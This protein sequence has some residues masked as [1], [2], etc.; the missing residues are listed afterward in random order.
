MSE[1]KRISN[2]PNHHFFG[3]HDLR[4]TN[5]KEDKVLSLEIEDISHPPLLKDQ[6]LA[7]FIDLSKNN[8]FRS[9]HRT[10][11]YNYPQGARQQWI[12]ETNF[13]TANVRRK[14]NW[15]AFISNADTCIVEE[16]LD[17]P[18]HVLNEK[19][20]DVFYINYSR[21]YRLGVYGY[22][23]IDDKFFKQDLPKKDG[24][25]I[26]NIKTKEK[27]LL[28]SI[29][30]IASCDEIK[31]KRTGFG[32]YV[33]HLSLNPSKNRIAFL[34][35][36]RVVD[37]GEITRLMTV[38]TDGT[39][40]RCLL[41]GF[42]SHFDWLDDQTLFIW[43]IEQRRACD[44]REAACLRLPF[45]KLGIKTLKKAVS[46]F[47]KNGL[48]TNRVN[49]K[50]FIKVIDSNVPTFQK[51]AEGVLT[52]DG[53]PMTS[54]FNRSYLISDTYPDGSG[55]RSLYLYNHLIEQNMIIEKFRMLDKIPGMSQ[56]DVDEV[57]QGIDKKIV[58]NLNIEKFIFHKSGYH[59]DLHPRWSC[60]GQIAFFDSIHEGN[61]QIYAVDLFDEL[62]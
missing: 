27:Q 10:S 35:R 24:L 18:I 15:G 2:G 36:Y 34:H 52:E 12:G 59:C 45:M 6:A 14:N 49:Q 29:Y 23:G 60:N 46:L 55:Y 40:L 5:Y 26:G 7:G 28:V 62:K 3:F 17:F 44:M 38:G 16:K 39:D 51:T 56:V 53:H 42:L 48:N 37:G 54:P 4:I 50:T 13:F 22:I 32:H 11:A 41:K 33:T 19:T 21:L 31:P 8:E 20:Y 30:D 61:R 9:I 25:F 47:R 1:L 58:K 43:G 57:F